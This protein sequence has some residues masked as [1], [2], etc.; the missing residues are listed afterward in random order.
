MPENNFKQLGIAVHNYASTYQD[1]LPLAALENDSL[2][3]EKRLSWTVTLV[4]YIESGT[5]WSATDKS[6]GW[7]APSN[8]F[9]LGMNY[10]PFR[11]PSQWPETDAQGRILTAYVGIAGLGEGG[12]LR[13]GVFSFENVISLPAMTD[14]ETTFLFL[15]TSV[16]NGPWTAAGRPTLRSLDAG[17][18]Y[19]GIDGQYASYHRG[20]GTIAALA[21]GSVMGIN[22][23]MDPRVFEERAI[24]KRVKRN[25]AE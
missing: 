23:N 20:I 22:A 10:R 19:F 8:A 7:D 14:W 18:P 12:Q 4:P 11:C 5:V 15:E 16:S 2:P 13:R 21:D 6:A 1:R 9:L 25:G 17:E 3:P 24:V